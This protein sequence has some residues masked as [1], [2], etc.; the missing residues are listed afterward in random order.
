M[1]QMKFCP[2]F[3]LLGGMINEKCLQPGG[4]RTFSRLIDIP[5]QPG[6]VVQVRAPEVGDLEL[7]LVPCESDPEHIHLVRADGVFYGSD[8][9]D[10]LTVNDACHLQVVSLFLQ[11][12]PAPVCFG[13]VDL[14]ADNKVGAGQETIQ[15]LMVLDVIGEGRLSKT[16][17]DYEKQFFD[18][19]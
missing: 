16:N 8:S 11:N 9:G 14:L 7:L 3:P 12:D 19:H 5:R 4:R 10:P 13:A 6:V 15:E 2:H 18:H 1:K 17:Q